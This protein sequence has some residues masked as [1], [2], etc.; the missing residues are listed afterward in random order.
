MDFGIA[1][2]TNQKLGL[3]SRRIVSQVTGVDDSVAKALLQG[4]DGE[5]KTAILCNLASI[6]PQTARD[7]LAGCQGRLADAL[8]RAGTT[9]YPT[10]KEC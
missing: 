9:T 6:D 7:Q 8:A 5:V 4:C 10:A 2:A 1:K 3:R